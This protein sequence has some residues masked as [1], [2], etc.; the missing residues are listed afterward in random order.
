M[1]ARHQRTASRFGA[2]LRDGFSSWLR[3]LVRCEKRSRIVAKVSPPSRM[4]PTAAET[5][6]LNK[7]T[8]PGCG[9]RR[10]SKELPVHADVFVENH[11][12]L[13]S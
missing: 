1:N 2:E 11:S 9:H 4:C 10:Y 3:H 13:S 5:P 6:L 7:A 12:Q 8:L